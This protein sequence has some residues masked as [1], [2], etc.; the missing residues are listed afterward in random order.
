[1]SLNDT[2][3][4]TKRPKYSRALVLYQLIEFCGRA[5]RLLDVSAPQVLAK[6]DNKNALTYLMLTLTRESALIS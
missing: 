5:N 1:M 2:E 3:A 6:A 4:K